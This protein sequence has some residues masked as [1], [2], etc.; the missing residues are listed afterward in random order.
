M[1]EGVKEE[2]EEKEGKSSVWR[3]EQQMGRKSRMVETGLEMT[4]VR[5]LEGCGKVLLLAR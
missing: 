5:V 1:E 3:E 4:T 2:K